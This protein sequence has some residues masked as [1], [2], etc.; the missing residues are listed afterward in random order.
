MRITALDLVV[1]LDHLSRGAFH[2]EVGYENS[3]V[4]YKKMVRNLAERTIR[5]RV[6]EVES[7][8]WSCNLMSEIG[9]FEHPDGLSFD[10][11]VKKMLRGKDYNY[12]YNF[13]EEK[14]K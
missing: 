2:P 11:F 5:I 4:P 3:E 7:A 10:N 6:S 9:K 13:I 8:L 14:K 1:L 12:I